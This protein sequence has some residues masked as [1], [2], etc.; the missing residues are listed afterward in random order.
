[1]HTLIEEWGQAQKIGTGGAEHTCVWV[2][3]RHLV[4]IRECKQ[5]STDFCMV[6]MN[7]EPHYLPKVTAI[8]KLNQR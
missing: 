2:Q 6:Y 1:M 3:Q 7:F 8:L 5:A 4:T